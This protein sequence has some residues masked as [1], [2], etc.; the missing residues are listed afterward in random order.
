MR[1]VICTGKTVSVH[2]RRL[3]DVAVG[4]EGALARISWWIGRADVGGRE[5]AFAGWNYPLA[6]AT[7]LGATG[8]SELGALLAS[9]LGRNRQQP[10]ESTANSDE[11]AQRERDDT[12]HERLVFPSRPALHGNSRLRGLTHPVWDGVTLPTLRYWLRW[13]EA[14][15]KSAGRVEAG[16]GREEQIVRLKAEIAAREAARRGNTTPRES[17]RA[18]E[19]EGARSRDDAL[20]ATVAA[21]RRLYRE[22]ARRD[23]LL[24][25]VERRRT[26]VR[27]YLEWARAH[28]GDGSTYRMTERP[29]IRRAGEA[30]RL[31][32]E[33]WWGV[34]VYSCFDATLGARTVAPHFQRPLPPP[35]AEAMLDDIDF[36]RGS[37][38][39]HRIQPALKGAKHALIAA[40]ADHQLFYDVLHSREDFDTRY[41]RLRGARMR[42]WGRT[43]CFDLLL[44]AGAL[45]VGGRQYAPDYAY[46]AGSTGPSGGFT[47]VFGESL[48]SDERVAWAE[49]LLWLWREAWGEVAERVG[50][51]WARA[52]LEPRDQENFLCIY[53]ERR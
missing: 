21:R 2:V 7:G 20:V 17:K 6:R 42:Q 46:L 36:P 18:S 53:Q 45:G 9:R 52:P 51:E 29:D 39:G 5:V 41:L 24:M 47:R 33:P 25:L 28:D 49:S 44:R 50:V 4:D 11:S 16:W 38:G 12:T 37:I 22:S 10:S 8:E 26:E 23:E 15:T 1:A 30:A 43:T 19:R 27:N 3:L 34:I 31:F 14:E 35:E 13:W 40:C 48:A 32:A